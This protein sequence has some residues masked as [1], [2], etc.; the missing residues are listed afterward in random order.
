MVGGVRAEQG[1][2]PPTAGDRKGDGHWCREMLP[3]PH[4]CTQG[5]WRF[6]GCVLA[7]Q[8]CPHAMEGHL[9]DIELSQEATVGSP[10]GTFGS[11]LNIT[12]K[13]KWFHGK[14]TE[15]LPPPSAR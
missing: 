6:E 8:E 10:S 13:E 12:R 1:A 15:L 4:T 3:Q 5:S 14:I 7:R 11:M 9:S 2:L